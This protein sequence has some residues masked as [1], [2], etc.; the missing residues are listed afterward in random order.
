MTTK[1]KS[2]GHK[3]LPQD[4]EA[5]AALL[6]SLM[7]DPAAIFEVSATLSVDSFYN[8]A[9]ALIYKTMLDLSTRS[10]P[11][12]PIG[13]MAELRR[14]GHAD[15]GDGQRQAESYLVN[16]LNSA[17][18]SLHATNY[19]RIVS[20]MST[21]RKII[22][23][24]QKAATLAWDETEPLDEV[25]ESVQGL[26][27]E[28]TSQRAKRGLSHISTDMAKYLEV[29]TDRF[30]NPVE[31]SGMPTGYRDLD[32]I[33]NGLKPQQ[34]VIVAG[35]P[36][37]GKTALQIGMCDMMSVNRGKRGAFF[38]LE[39]SKTELIDRVIGRRISVNL[40]NLQ[41]GKLTQDEQ[42]RFY[43]EYGRVSQA[44][45]FI[46]D[47]PGMTPAAIRSECL[48]QMA[49]T[50]L[51]YVLIDYLQLIIVPGGVSRYEQVSTAARSMKN[52]AKE[53]DVPVILASQLNRSL[54]ARGDKRPQ[55]SDL[56]DS[57]EIEEAANVVLML[58]R[59]EYYNQDSSQ[60]P[61][62]GEI[63]VSKQRNGPSGGRIDLFWQAETASYR[64]L[65]RQSINL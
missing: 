19:A 28:A 65:E 53:L 55:L 52:L 41:R 4:R 51:D 31:V 56:R 13:I 9:N 24:S 59:D 29:L 61:N 57:G 62:Q 36:G 40:Q 25:S 38:S 10:E 32:K 12:D 60:W 5:E 2:N 45:I 34:L 1:V 47:V 44:P 33:L 26:M 15:I 21:R 22:A 49:E 50:G 46:T 6:G 7:I 64:N 23:A 42:S 48:K 63:S 27:F 30:E 14:Y 8:D 18:S 54:E 3:L 37:M 35:R 43:Q 11:L 58:Y 17:T 20:E 16:L 39:M